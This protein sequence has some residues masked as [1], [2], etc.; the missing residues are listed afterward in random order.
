MA[1]ENTSNVNELE[2]TQVAN[3][4]TKKEE[5]SED[6]V[7]TQQYTQEQ[8]DGMMANVRRKAEA[9]AEKR[10]AGIDV[11]KYRELMEREEKIELEKQK[12][13][14]EFDT[15]LK[16]QAEKF[17]A[18]INTLTG[19]LTKIKVDGALLSA[20]SSAKAIN[21]EQVVSLVRNQIRMS[22]TGEVE[23]VDK[24]GTVRYDETGTPMT[25]DKLV[26]E[27]LQ[28]NPHFV[29]AGVPGGGSKSNTAPSTNTSDVD[30]NTLDLD[31]PEQR[32]LYRELRRKK[33]PNINV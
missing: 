28:S 23:V 20:A 30:I 17:G 15:I 7:S 29:Q 18:K 10:F 27:F 1:D 14:G 19:E 9:A 31:D 11:E 26:A 6:V 13:K 16:Q 33:Y 3:E 24:N 5:K 2:T 22:E 25:T 4:D 12:K 32:A 21:P 8:I